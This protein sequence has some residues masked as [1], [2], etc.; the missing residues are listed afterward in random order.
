MGSKVILV[1]AVLLSSG[2]VTA[3]LAQSSAK[4]TDVIM[5]SQCN[6]A[7]GGMAASALREKIRGS[8]GYT[9]ATGPNVGQAEY[10][11][12]L[13]CTAIPGYEG[14]ASAVSYIFDVVFADG[15]RLDL[16]PGIGVV[17]IQGISEW[18]NNV[19]S[20]FDNWG[21]SPQAQAYR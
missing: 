21:S 3:V 2:A 20:Q 1:T 15:A 18:T 4:K 7:V 17:G 16:Y 12:I 9:I 6:D 14:H 11:I 5:T 19:F 13:T 8:N 10:E